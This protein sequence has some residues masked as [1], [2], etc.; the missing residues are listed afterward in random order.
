MAWSESPEPDH[1]DYT[2]HS[3][4]HSALICDRNLRIVIDGQIM[5]PSITPTTLDEAKVWVER[6]M[7]VEAKTDAYRE[8]LLDE[9]GL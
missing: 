2:F 5:A 9:D 6:W 7:D 4:N 8:S 3:G 1:M